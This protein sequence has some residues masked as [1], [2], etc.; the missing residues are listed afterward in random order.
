[1]GQST[2]T[3]NIDELITSYIDNQISDPELKSQIEAMLS[4]DE[5]LNRKY[6]S[7]LLTKQMLSRRL[8]EI[9][10]PESTYQN[11]ISSLDSLISEAGNNTG[12][13][14]VE[15]P[16]F[17]Q[18]IKHTI[19]APFLGIPRYAFGI[20]AVFIVGASLVFDGGGKKTK[21]PYI[22]AGTEKSIMVQ[23]VNSFHKILSGDVKPELSSSNA[24]EVEKYVHDKA[25]FEAY[26]PKIDNYQL[27][28]VVCN[29]YNGQNLAHL[30]YKDRDDEVIYIYQTLVTSVQKKNLELPDDV[31]NE[32]IKAKYYMCDEVDDNNCTMTLWFKGNVICV[33]MS[34]M[35]KKD[36]YAAFTSFNK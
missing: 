5:K 25:H 4:K 6:K 32:I 33:S 16:T 21:N 19:T 26:V 1:M 15:Y 11:V 9:Q 31:T 14:K 13:Q 7:E 18:T 22:L 35:P 10:V 23:A 29:Q 36:M 20:I 8:P 30:I 27:T 17:W 2:T 12:A 3:F 28:G 34:T 24:A